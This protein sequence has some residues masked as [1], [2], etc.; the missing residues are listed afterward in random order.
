[1]LLKNLQPGDVL[2]F[3]PSSFLGKVV[4]WATGSEY[5]HAAMYCGEDGVAEMRE[6]LGGRLLPLVDHAGETID[7]FRADVPIPVKIVVLK[8]QDLLKERYSF[9]HGVAAFLLRKIRSGYANCFALNATTTAIIVRRPSHRRTAPPES[10]FAPAAPTGRRH[11]ATSPDP[12]ASAPS[13]G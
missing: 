9:W 4:A 7:V 13:D 1:M 11:P 10:T 12:R 3:K 2:L 6:F 8:M 5:C